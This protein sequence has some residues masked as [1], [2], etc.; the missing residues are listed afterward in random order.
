MQTGGQASDVTRETSCSD[1]IS[2]RAKKVE[3]IPVARR[4]LNRS[5]I[6]NRDSIQR[7]GK[8]ST[9]ASSP[10]EEL[11]TTVHEAGKKGGLSCLRNRGRE[12]FSEIGRT[13]QQAMRHKYP[14][15][16]V[17]W[18]KRGGRPKKCNLKD[19]VG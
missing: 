9:L 15:M 4:T 7:H 13:G 17:K 10:S 14:G 19:I 11:A 5:S 2:R 1:G 3:K 18:G 16:A 12:F 8:L 6:Y